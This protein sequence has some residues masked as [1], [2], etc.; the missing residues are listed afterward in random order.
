MNIIKKITKLMATLTIAG[1]IFAPVSVLAQGT[2]TLAVCEGL[3]ITG[4]NCAD[5]PGQTNVNSVVKT[6][7]N[8]LSLVV[9]IVAV[10]MVIIGG[11]KYVISSGDSSNINSAKN[12]ILYALIGLVIVA[13]A[14][15][16]VRFTFNSVTKLPKCGA[17]QSSSAASPCAP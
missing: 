2:N 10:I 3:A 6:V 16:I 8:I 9:G 11:L 4:G 12:T 1:V 13:L 7:I 17:G 14:Q 5:Q 15:V